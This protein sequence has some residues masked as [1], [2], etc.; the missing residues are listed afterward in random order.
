[1]KRTPLTRKTPLRRSWL[2]RHATADTA[3]VGSC[4][5]SHLKPHRAS[6][7]W[8]TIC[9]NGREVSRL[10]TAT[11]MREYRS[12]VEEIIS[13][14]KHKEQACRAAAA[15]TLNIVRHLAIVNA[16]RRRLADLVGVNAVSGNERSVVDGVHG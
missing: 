1:M 8:I 14:V 13:Y 9:P 3:K 6:A 16:A 4:G 2:P 5:R 11:S 10:L 15:V 12:H 7:A